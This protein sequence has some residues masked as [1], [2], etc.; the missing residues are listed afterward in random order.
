L[1][2]VNEIDLWFSFDGG[3]WTNSGLTESGTSGSFDFAPS[4]GDGTYD[5]YTIAIDNVGNVESAPGAAD[6]STVYDTTAPASSCTSP[7]YANSTPINV[8][9]TA[10]DSLSGIASV[11]LWY[12]YDGQG[13]TDSELD[14]SGTSGSFDFEPGDGDGTYEFYTISTDNA[15][16]AESAP[17]EADDSSDYDTAA[18]ASSC[19][20]ATYSK[21]SPI[22]VDYT[23]SDTLSG[24]NDVALWFSLNGGAWTDSGLTETGTS[25]SFDF[26][27]SDGDGTY[28]FYTIATD[29]AGNVEEAPGTA[30]DSTVY[31][32]AAPESSCTSP[33]YANSSPIAVSFSSS[34]LVSG[35]SSVAL[36]YRFN[37][38]AW[39]NSG[40]S[41]GGPS[42]SFN[43][44]P[45]AGDGLYE[46][47]TI[48]TDNATNVVVRC[49]C[50]EL[51]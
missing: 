25:G 51:V 43:F 47:Y 28:Q 30:D 8:S 6:D 41:D 20:S 31:D 32:T 27:P 14:E 21:S 15:G 48:A 7:A 39:T 10:N 24:V 16:N 22:V 37:S 40:L 11:A 35:V 5:F 42:G 4:S 2:G 17:G 19:S 29:N 38:G 1:S 23:A 18:P 46:F 26:S 50:V 3:A 33:I 12:N 49:D 44:S 13:W 9:F 45:A 34:D 36:W